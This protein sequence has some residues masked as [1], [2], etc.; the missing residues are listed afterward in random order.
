MAFLG[1]RSHVSDAAATAVCRM[2]EVIEATICAREATSHAERITRLQHALEECAIVQ[3]AIVAALAV[4]LEALT[5]AEAAER[6][7]R[8]LEP[9]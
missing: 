8:A 6:C 1:N 3:R 4:E 9:A 7:R 2:G 5:L